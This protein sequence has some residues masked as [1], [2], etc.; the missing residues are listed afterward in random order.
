MQRA[1]SS[2]D[3]S[4]AGS[5]NDLLSDLD[6]TLS[7]SS[8]LCG[9]VTNSSSTESSRK[10][11]QT[12]SSVVPQ[13]EKRRHS[14]GSTDECRSFKLPVFSPDIQKCINKDA[15]YTPTQTQRLIKESCLALHGHCW[16][17]GNTVS[18]D[19]KRALA[20]KLYD[21][22]PNTLGDPISAKKSPEVRV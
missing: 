7:R 5:T 15:F 8:R 14:S 12:E 9:S 13:S 2:L 1:R 6:E 18:N 3:L 4:N 16:E 10:R 17:N 21:L 11:S 20:K 19:D 22:A